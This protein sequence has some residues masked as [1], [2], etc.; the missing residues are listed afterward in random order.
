MKVLIV[1]DDLDTTA[2]LAMLLERQGY[3]VKIADTVND[4]AMALAAHTFDVLITD[5]HLPDGHGTELIHPDRPAS[6]RAAILVTGACEEGQR[7]EWRA[8]GFDRC[9]TKPVDIQ[10]IIQ[11]LHLL[12]TQASPL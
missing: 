3:Q 7:G 8:L 2:L 9:L 1:D 6:L 4:A 5:L 12:T 10:Q 11:R